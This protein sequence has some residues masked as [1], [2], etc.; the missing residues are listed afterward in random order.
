MSQPE[1]H[2][3]TCEKCDVVH[4]RLTIQGKTRCQNHS[5]RSGLQCGAIALRGKAQ[6]FTH[7]GKSKRTLLLDDVLGG[8][9]RVGYLAVKNDTELTRTGEQNRIWRGRERE[10]IGRITAGEGESAA[11][12]IAARN[13]LIRVKLGQVQE[14]K[15]VGTGLADIA[16]GMEQLDEILIEGAAREASFDDLQQSTE[17]I[18]KCSETEIRRLRAEHQMLSMDKVLEL[19]ALLARIALKRIETAEGKTAFLE[20]LKLLEAGEEVEV[21]TVEVLLGDGEP[22]VPA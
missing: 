19:A 10:I 18:R 15:Q 5:K 16:L 9:L 13:A 20:D 6:C 4:E 12:W 11:G 2:G 14:M 22:E 8:L 3:S 7:V 1:P 21:E 17:Q